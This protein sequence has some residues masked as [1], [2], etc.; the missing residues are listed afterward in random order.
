MFE[1]SH[2]EEF[3]SLRQD[4]RIIPSRQGGPTDTWVIKCSLIMDFAGGT[5]VPDTLGSFFFFK[6]HFVSYLPANRYTFQ[7][8]TRN[9]QVSVVPCELVNVIESSTR[10]WVRIPAHHPLAVQSW[11]CYLTSLCLICPICNMGILFLKVAGN[12]HV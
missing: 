4:L 7:F 11:V 1:T 9:I 12:V 8:E 6:N 2:A 10:H 5:E 3:G